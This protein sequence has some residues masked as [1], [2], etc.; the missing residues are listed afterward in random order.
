VDPFQEKINVQSTHQRHLG[1]Y[2]NKGKLYIDNLSKGKIGVVLKDNCDIPA[3]FHMEA[4]TKGWTL[5]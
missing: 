1:D 4:V 2:G 3:I 5:L